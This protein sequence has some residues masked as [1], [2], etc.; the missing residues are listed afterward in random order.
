MANNQK[1]K[2]TGVLEQNK[3]SISLRGIISGKKKDDARKGFG[4]TESKTKDGKN[5]YRSIRFFLNTS[6]NNRIPVEL[7]GMPRDKVYAFPEKGE[8]KGKG[9]EIAWKDRF[10]F[11]KDGYVVMT[12]EYD[13][14][15]EIED[16]YNDGDSIVIVGKID[17]SHYIDKDGKKKNQYRFIISRVLPATEPV[18]F[19]KEG[20]VEQC[21]FVQ[22][23][24]IDSVTEEKSENKLYVNAF[25]INYGGKFEN[26]IFEVDTT[27]TALNPNNV[28]ALKFGDVINVNGIIHERALT[29][30]VEENDGW[31]TKAK[32]VR[33]KYRAL[34]ITGAD[35][36]SLERKKYKESDFETPAENGTESGWGSEPEINEDDSNDI[37][38]DLDD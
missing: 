32:A 11:K 4:Y 21:K 22:D 29:E 37:P 31:G 1:E 20:F 9:I 10:N 3:G 27:K 14:V 26:A 35:G 34:E 19:T 23:I 16:K 33:S 5:T 13:L 6:P 7:F 18:D 25:I 2:Y 24:V 30:E 36:A 38:F 8:K 17:F 28:K 15:K 12:S